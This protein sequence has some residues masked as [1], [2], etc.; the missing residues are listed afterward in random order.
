MEG[1]VR[2]EDVGRAVDNGVASMKQSTEPAFILCQKRGRVQLCAEPGTV[3]ASASPPS[4]V[5]YGERCH[6]GALWHSAADG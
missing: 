4:G 3:R 1:G 5:A 6:A 2:G